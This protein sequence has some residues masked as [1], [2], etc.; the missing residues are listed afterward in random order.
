MGKCTEFLIRKRPNQGFGDVFIM[1]KAF[2]FTNNQH[3]V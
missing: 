3:N 2:N 1:L